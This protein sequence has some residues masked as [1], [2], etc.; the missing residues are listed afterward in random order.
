[1]GHKRSLH[2]LIDDRARRREKALMLGIV[3]KVWEKETDTLE[4]GNIEVNVQSRGFSHEFRRV[5]VLATDHVG[6]ATVPQVGDMAV[7]EWTMG[8]GRQPA[9]IG[10]TPTDV[11]RSPNARAGHWR[12]MWRRGAPGSGLL[13]EAERKD[14]QA[15]DPEIV[16]FAVKDDGLEDPRAWLGIDMWPDINTPEG[17]LIRAETDGH[18]ELETTDEGYLDVTIDEED[19]RVTINEEGNIDVYVE[20]GDVDIHVEEG[21]MNFHTDEGNVTASTDEGNIDV[22]TEDGDVTTR[23]AHGTVDIESARGDINVDAAYGNVDVTAGGNITLDAGNIIGLSAPH[24]VVDSDEGLRSIEASSTAYESDEITESVEPTVDGESSPT[25]APGESIDI[26]IGASDLAGDGAEGE[27]VTVTAID[28]DDD[29]TVAGL[30]VGDAET[31]GSDGMASF[32]GVS[33]DGPDG[34]SATIAL[35]VEDGPESAIA[36]TID[37]GG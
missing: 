27:E 21:D 9:V 13:L 3:S 31:T 4:E 33:F 20:E 7:V 16:R 18:I 8:R 17:P 37:G 10:F 25:V 30:S 36:V 6:H 28:H 1:M 26:T 22:L 29:V 12:H 19:I 24:V 34:G 11:E 15:G 14:H 2:D 35:G 32:A 5:P 23:T